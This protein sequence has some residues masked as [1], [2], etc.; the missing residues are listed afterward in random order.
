[1]LAEHKRLNSTP[2]AWAKCFGGR[3]DFDKNGMSELGS[4]LLVKHWHVKTYSSIH[5]MI[6]SHA[7]HECFQHRHPAT[8]KLPCTAQRPA[9]P[10]FVMPLKLEQPE[11]W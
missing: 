3:R 2:Q 9:G 10:V 8:A 11:P 4:P 7:V 1:M 6:G 5:H